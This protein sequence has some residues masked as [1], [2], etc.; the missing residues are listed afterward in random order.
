MWLCFH[1]NHLVLKNNMMEND[2]TYCDPLWETC[3]ATEIEGEAETEAIR[4]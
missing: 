2:T 4:A 1:T 3:T